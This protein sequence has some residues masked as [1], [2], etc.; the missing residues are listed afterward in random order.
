M[1]YITLIRQ[2][3]SHVCALHLFPSIVFSGAKARRPYSRLDFSW[4]DPRIKMKNLRTYLFVCASW[5]TLSCEASIP[6]AKLDRRESAIEQSVT[7]P[8][9]LSI[10]IVSSLHPRAQTGNFTNT[11][12]QQSAAL[13]RLG[14]SRC[15]WTLP[16]LL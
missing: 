12:L 9:S 1:K 14:T 15:L 10:G 5:L 11:Y 7:K 3:I 8:K 6:H 2:H 16:T 13:P 4:F